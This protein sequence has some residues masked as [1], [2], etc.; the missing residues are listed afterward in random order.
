MPTPFSMSGSKRS[1]SSQPLLNDHVAVLPLV[2]DLLLADSRA[3]RYLIF[4]TSSRRYHEIAQPP[5]DAGN[6]AGVPGDR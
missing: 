6:V 4:P 5:R 3:H 2:I 1:C